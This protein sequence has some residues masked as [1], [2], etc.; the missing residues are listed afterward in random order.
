MCTAISL[1]CTD[2]YFG[3]NLDY[4]VDFGEKIT[5]TP[6]NYRINF[7]NGRVADRHYAIIGMAVIK[8]SYPLYFDGTNE[9]GLSMAGLLFDGNAVYNKPLAEKENV[10]SYELILWILS[11]CKN[12]QEAVKL[13]KRTNITEGAFD[14]HTKPSPLHWLVAD[15]NSAIT[16]EQTRFGLQIFENRA[17]VL[18]NNPPFESQMLNLCNYMS[19]SPNETE[20][21]FSNML[22]LEPYS[23]GMG[24]LGLPGDLSSASRFVRSTFFAKN[25]V[26]EEKEEYI[27]EQ[28][29]H[30]LY[31]V[32]QHKGAVRVGNGC[33]VTQ[34]S[35]CCNTDKGIYY[36]TG[37]HNSTI[38][39]VSM[40][41]ENL[42]GSLP[43]AYSLKKRRHILLQN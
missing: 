23:R 8:N 2:N 37:C 3:R 24:A 21:S 34:Y 19:L 36:Y 10:A 11:Q 26:F 31:S 18:T 9:A 35:S 16:V 43:V 14:E 28:F 13:L 4:E 5:I 15:K 25:L 42:D 29:F 39:A 7:S 41:N 6:R 12:V 17:G 22:D 33:E 38:N 20:N 30:I 40:Y 32:Y 1:T 27:V